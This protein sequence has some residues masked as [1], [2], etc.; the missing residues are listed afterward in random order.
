MAIYADDTTLYSNCDWTSDLW[1]QLELA[2][3]LESDLWDTANWG[4]KWMVWRSTLQF[5]SPSNSG[6]K[7]P[8]FQ[9]VN[10]ID[11]AI[12]PF[13]YFSNP[14]LSSPKF[15]GNVTPMK[16]R[17]NTKINSCG[18]VK[19]FIFRKLKN[20]FKCFLCK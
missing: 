18:K 16:C 19:F 3:E 17:I 13:L 2:S 20:N 8:H 6:L 9:P 1:Q 4:R 15:S 10:I 5:R 12:F 14:P 7:S 11:M